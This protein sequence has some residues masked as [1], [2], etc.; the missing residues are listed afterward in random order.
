MFK[1]IDYKNIYTESV[2]HKDI[3]NLVLEEF[4]GYL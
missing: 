3:M 2:K 4:M 1:E